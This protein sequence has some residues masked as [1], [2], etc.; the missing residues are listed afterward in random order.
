MSTQ[1]HHGLEALSNLP[2]LHEPTRGLRAEEDANA[3][4]EGRNKGWTEL[5]TPSDAASVFD[6]HV[7]GEAQKDT[8]WETISIMWSHDEH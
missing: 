1:A 8:Y 3:E 4:D 7:G 6:N 5:E 2:M